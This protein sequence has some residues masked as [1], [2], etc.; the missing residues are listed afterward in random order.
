MSPRALVASG[1]LSVLSLGLFLGNRPLGINPVANWLFQMFVLPP[2]LG[3]VVLAVLIARR[4]RYLTGAIAGAI[5]ALAFGFAVFVVPV[6]GATISDDVSALLGALVASAIFGLI[7]GAI[8]ELLVWLF[9]PVVRA[10]RSAQP[11]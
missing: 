6:A 9:A 2:A 11:R 4:A 10:L 1:L 5:G 7:A 3:S 8:G